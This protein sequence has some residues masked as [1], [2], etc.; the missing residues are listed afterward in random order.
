MAIAAAMAAG[1][2]H[3]LSAGIVAILSIQPTKKE[4][5]QTALD[6]YLA[7]LSA[8]AVAYLCLEAADYSIP[9]FYIYLV[10]YIFLCQ[11]R[12]WE[13]AIAMNSVLVSHFLSAGNMRPP[14]LFNEIGIFAIGVGTGIAA[15]L[16]LH[17]N[18]GYIEALKEETDR[19][20]KKILYRMSRRMIDR[21]ISDYNGACFE[22][23]RDSIRQ[24]QN[25]AATNYK[26]QFSGGEDFDSAYIRMR[27]RQCQVLYEMYKQVRAIRT[28][29]V[30]AHRISDF[31]A[32]VAVEYH[33]DNNGRE[34]LAEF[35][36]LDRSMK[37]KPLPKERAEFEDRARCFCLLRYMEEFL[38]IK[39]E[40]GERYGVKNAS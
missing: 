4:T 39:V 7:F 14:A 27:D 10:A 36:W 11:W 1:L 26:N 18:T 28:T 40:F 30:T 32:K 22:I 20:M 13:N 2:E 15:N 12:R 21:D 38:E 31:L 9:G 17:R 25:V 3:P 6:R 23:L 34:L 29:P 24:A 37:S 16:H 5:L 19:Q 35:H 33:R 8:L